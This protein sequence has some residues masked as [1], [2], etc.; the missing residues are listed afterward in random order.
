MFVANYVIYYNG[1][2][3]QSVEEVKAGTQCNKD[4]KIK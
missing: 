2:L 4:E 1:T 3:L